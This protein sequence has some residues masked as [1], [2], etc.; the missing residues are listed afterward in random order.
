MIYYCGLILSIF[1]MRGIS[2]TFK[3]KDRIV[4]FAFS[5]ILVILFQGLRSFS[6]GVDLTS[7]IPSYSEIGKYVPFSFT[8]K[9]LNYEIG[10]ILLNKVIY[11]L[12]FS[13][14]GFLIVITMIIQAPIF[15]TMYKYSETPL[16][17]VFVYFAF[18]NFVM[19]FSGLR[20]AV[21]MSIC[22]AAY[23][24][25]KNRKPIWFYILIA[26]AFCFHKSALICLLVYPL[27]HIK[28]KEIAFPF[29]LLG[30]AT[31]F[32]FKNQI[33]ALLSKIYYGEEIT[34]Q[35]TGAYTMFVMFLLLYIISNFLRS[36]DI[37]Y[38]G[39][40][41]ILLII[42]CIYSLASIHSFITRMSYPLSLYLTLFIPKI[43][44]RLKWKYNRDKIIVYGLCNVLCIACFMNFIGALNTLPFS[45]L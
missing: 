42:V 28:I 24:F 21:S 20:Q 13:E 29:V 17:S 9:Y 10:Y 14:R 11:A 37:D 5:A 8:A 35:A 44:G 2:L 1:V 32:A 3:N 41:N 36:D 38:N 6:V 31:C 15:Y 43:V 4:F 12:G 39:L 45:F 19:T 7:Y 22:F 33:F 23:G 27:Y 30:I 34:S 16:L 40:M 25:V 18:G 26:L